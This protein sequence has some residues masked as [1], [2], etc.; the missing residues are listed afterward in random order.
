[1]YASFGVASKEPTRD[2]Y[3]NSTE[4]SRPEAE[5]LYNIETGYKGE[6]GS[7]YLGVNG[8]AMLYKDQ[9]VLTG[10]INDVGAYIRDNVD[11]SYRIGIELEGGVQIIPELG[12][13]ANMTLSQNKISEFTEYID[14]YDN[15]VQIERN[16]TDTD[17][18]FSPNF[19]ANSIFNYSKNGFNAEFWTKYVSR[20]YLDNTQ[21][22]NR[23]ID[24][25]LVND[26]NLSY[27]ISGLDFAKA[28]TATLKIANL[29]DVEYET[30][31]YTYGYIFGGEERV[32]YYYPQA[33]RNFLL[34][35]KWEF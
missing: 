4:S 34:Q 2:E 20:Q 29:L 1:V 26:L 25:Y 23:S 21:D 24:P 15:G 5:T 16:F 17:I 27:R 35:V 22:E 3:V 8:Y 32:N 6:F 9:L 19:I 12:W 14:D 28:V 11:D 33:G 31:G 7:Y 10:Q 13:S 18:S 30:N